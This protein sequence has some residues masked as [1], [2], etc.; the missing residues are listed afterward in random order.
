MDKFP[1]SI[2]A[3]VWESRLVAWFGAFKVPG[4]M[5]EWFQ[6][7]LSRGYEESK[8]ELAELTRLNVSATRQASVQ[9][10]RA[11]KAEAALRAQAPKSPGPE[12]AAEYP[13]G[14]WYAKEAEQY[15]GTLNPGEWAY[16]V[17]REQDRK[18]TKLC[19]QHLREIFRVALR[20]AYKQGRLSV[21][22]A[23]PESPGPQAN[24]HQV[25][26]GSFRPFI[27]G[28]RIFADT[29]EECP[30]VAPETP[31]LKSVVT[32]L[33]IDFLR[34]LKLAN[35]RIGVLESKS[36]G[37]WSKRLAECERG[38]DALL[39]QGAEDHDAV[40]GIQIGIEK[41]LGD[42][43]TKARRLD[44][45]AV[46]ELDKRVA[47]MEEWIKPMSCWP[48]S[49]LRDLQKRIEEC[50]V[51]IGSKFMAPERNLSGEFVELSK[52]VAELGAGKDM[53][54]GQLH[55]VQKRLGDLE[56]QSRLVL[57]ARDA[58]PKPDLG[59]QG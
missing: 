33:K 13:P 40:T 57:G 14:T 45:P 34:G 7:A 16:R 5:E 31:N 44:R 21:E 46:L 50:E 58:E 25:V 43:E 54:T 1:N 9:Y 15:P 18:Q 55:E 53:L 28:T 59:A 17:C 49:R 3:K 8:N 51:R 56:T 12:E 39:R 29:G 35:A 2:D 22:T 10:M 30:D 36:G 24:F 27:L 26:P 23:A 20:H 37:D 48:V 6:A 4:G 32:Q 47:D 52:R 19:W 41:R 38:I 11:E 42:L